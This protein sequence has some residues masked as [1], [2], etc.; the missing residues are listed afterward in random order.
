MALSTP[1]TKLLGIKHPIFL[2]GMNVSGTFGGR[3]LGNEGRERGEAEMPIDLEGEGDEGLKYKAKATGMF[4]VHNRV[5]LE[6]PEWR[7]HPRIQRKE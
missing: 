5:L 4:T 1:I 2:A 7:G 3:A 6:H